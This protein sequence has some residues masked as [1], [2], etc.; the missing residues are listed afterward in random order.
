MILI[1]A[2]STHE[3]VFHAGFNVEDVKHP[4]HTTR[5]TVWDVAGRAR[6]R[7]QWRHFFAST[8]VATAMARPV[9][10]S[11]GGCHSS[12]MSVSCW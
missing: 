11:A 5:F 6:A 8:Q 2:R 3:T 9:L 1:L 7:H 10:V 12:K 4:Q